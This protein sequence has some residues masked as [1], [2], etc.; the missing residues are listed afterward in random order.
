M[1]EKSLE[2][3]PVSDELDLF[4]QPPTHVF[5]LGAIDRDADEL[6]VHD[7]IYASS[8][9]P[10]G[11]PTDIAPAYVGVDAALKIANKLDGVFPPGPR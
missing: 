8:H 9:L 11:I 3:H 5:H 1:G 7:G 2:F 4:V 6:H 10:G